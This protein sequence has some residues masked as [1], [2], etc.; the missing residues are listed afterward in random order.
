MELIFPTSGAVVNLFLAFKLFV[1]CVSMVTL[2]KT[3]YIVETAVIIWMRR[4]IQTSTLRL[5]LVSV[6]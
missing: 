6:A 4:W 2:Q 1:H 5:H 3:V